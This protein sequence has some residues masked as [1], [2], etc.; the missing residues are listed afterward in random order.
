M[1][2]CTL[3]DSKKHK[4]RIKSQ[5]VELNSDM[6]GEGKLAAAISAADDLQEFNDSHNNPEHAMPAEDIESVDGVSAESAR[7]E[8]ERQS[9]KTG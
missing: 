9:L 1:V 4:R 3:W 6:T 2:R 7:G 8:Q 5:S